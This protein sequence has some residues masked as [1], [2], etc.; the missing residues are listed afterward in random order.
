MK[1]ISLAAVFLAAAVILGSTPA[2]ANPGFTPV[3]LH[4]GMNTP[5]VAV[6]QQYL[7]LNQNWNYL[8]YNGGYTGYFGSITIAG[9]KGWQRAAGYQ[10]TGWIVIGSSQWNKLRREA[11]HFQLPR[12]IDAQTI[13]AARQSGWA[14]D[15][16][17]SPGQ[18]TV[19]RYNRYKHKMGVAL[20]IAASYGGFIDGKYRPSTNGLFHIQ[21][22]YGVNY[23]SHSPGEPWNG[24]PMPYATCYYD[25]ECLH[26]DPLGPSHGCIHIPSMSAAIYINRLPLGTMVVVHQ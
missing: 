15:A 1:F 17:K 8:R 14:I 9:L 24:A 22:E 16:S 4:A 2:A 13:G 10:P 7:R 11:M 26:Y 25:G 20:S 21:A 6:L 23:V 5:G 12:Y 18:V 3:K 19:L